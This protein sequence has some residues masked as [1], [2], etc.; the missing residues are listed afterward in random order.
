MAEKQKALIMDEDAMKRAINRISYEIIEKNKGADDLVLAGIKTRG[1]FL[2]RRMAD[3]I[4]EVE[5]ARPQVLA[6]DI[7]AFRDD[8]PPELR[9]VRPVLPDDIT[10]RTVVLVDDV[11]F[12]GRTVR[13]AIEALSAIGR[14]RRIQLAALVDRGHREVPIRCDYVGKNLPTAL[15]EKVRV[16]MREIDGRDGILILDNYSEV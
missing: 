12:T 5:G 2:A 6:L 13:A 16:Q 9:P 3:K 7:A 11:L 14:A 4:E 8:V 1:E 15:S 10:G